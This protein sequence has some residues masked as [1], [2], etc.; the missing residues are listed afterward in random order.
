MLDA[1]V[2]AMSSRRAGL[3]GTVE[4]SGRSLIE[5]MVAML[6]GV[7][8][9]GVAAS[10]FLSMRGGYRLNHIRVELDESGR[11]ALDQMAQTIR[12]AGYGPAD[13]SLPYPQ[14]SKFDRSAFRPLLGCDGGFLSPSNKD[15]QVADTCAVV[16]G[17]AEDDG[18]TVRLYR[19]PGAGLSLRDCADQAVPDTE[20]YVVNRY[21]VNASN[22]LLCKGNGGVVAQPLVENVQD[23]QLRYL[24]LSLDGKTLGWLKGSQMADEDWRK[25]TAV[26]ICLLLRSAMREGMSSAR[27]YVDCAGNTVT[28]SD[29]YLYRRYTGNYNLRNPVN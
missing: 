12:A 9:A 6:L 2:D 19:A 1:D 10:V 17:S 4:Q 15:D 21:Y 16:G 23:L 3:S 8:I 22:T 29:G 13:L 28:R 25:V 18:M 5:L 7:I 24:A 26:E 11:Y 14:G 27:S 20:I